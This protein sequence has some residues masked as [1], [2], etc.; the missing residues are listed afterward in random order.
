M[1]EQMSLAS[2][3]NRDRYPHSP[4]YKRN[5]TSQESATRIAPRTKTLRDRC[6]SV[7]KFEPLSPDEIALRLGESVLSVRPRCSELL[8]LGKIRE[9]DERRANAS[10][11]F[12]HVLELI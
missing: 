2:Y 5:G 3:A 1:T 8:A 10:G 11:H 6:L 12:A 9:T 4:G 7:L